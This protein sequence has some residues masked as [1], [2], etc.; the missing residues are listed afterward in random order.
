MNRDILDE[1]ISDMSVQ[2]AT[3]RIGEDV[4]IG[5]IVQPPVPRDTVESIETTDA[6]RSHLYD[7]SDIA[8][9]INHVG[10]P[11]LDQSVYADDRKYTIER[12]TVAELKITQ[13]I[14]VESYNREMEHLSDRLG[15]KYD[16]DAMQRIRDALDYEIEVSVEEEWTDLDADSA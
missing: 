10:D 1:H 5:P 4:E 6:V 11:T 15:V 12:D 7:I 9:A 14:L 3:E 8:L 2:Y 16:A 13:G